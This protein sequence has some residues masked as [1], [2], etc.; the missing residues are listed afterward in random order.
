MRLAMAD[1]DDDE[2]FTCTGQCEEWK[3]RNAWLVRAVSEG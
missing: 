2:C 3:G 1:D